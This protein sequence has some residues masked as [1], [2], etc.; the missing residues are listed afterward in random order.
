MALQQVRVKFNGAWTVLQYNPATGRYEGYI[1][2][3][4]T[5]I[6][7]PGGY[8]NLT[9]EAS[10][11]SGE[12]DDISG[13]ILPALRL[14]TRETAAPT[15]E[16]VSPP[17]GWL[18]TANPTFVFRAQDESGGSGID[19]ASAQATIDGA[20]VPCTVAQS[21]AWYTLTFAGTGL[22]EGP[23]TVTVSV[24]D[25]DGNQT[26]ASAAYQV[27]TVPP[28]LYLF[29]PYLRHVVDDDSVY[30]EGE[31]RDSASAVALTVGGQVVEVA[32]GKFALTVPLEVGENT[33]PIVARD[34]AGNQTG[35]ELYIIRLVTDRTPA[36]LDAILELIQR[37]VW[38]WTDAEREWYNEAVQRGAY[39]TDD[40]N[41]VGAAVRFLSG[42]LVDHGYL[43]V[44]TTPRTDWK[45]SSAPTQP[46][47]AG[48]LNNVAHVRDAQGLPMPP[49]PDTIRHLT[50]QD[51]N[52]IEAALVEADSVFPRYFAWTAGELTAGGM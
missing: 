42:A 1:T 41:R 20:A 28:E 44:P 12:A 49:I 7:Q 46:E 30:I 8:Y 37:P 22:S 17:A 35:E 33:I 34:A 11:D 4:A 43:P 32:D 31:A 51:A 14:V 3:Q 10:N 25:R 47:M 18:T 39:N 36:D 13:D 6:H 24:S 38:D 2:P 23:H 9:A 5:S 21:G 19:T 16:L 15:L 50:E 29:R 26:A 45:Q 40:L 48:Y 52:Q 27:D